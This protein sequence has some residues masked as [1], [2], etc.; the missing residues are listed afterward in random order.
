MCVSPRVSESCV[1]FPGIV[2]VFVFV[3]VAARVVEERQKSGRRGLESSAD[4][5]APA[6]LLVRPL[7]PE[8][9]E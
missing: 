4:E 6:V 5:D 1:S 3:F 2:F 9:D 7:P 8:E